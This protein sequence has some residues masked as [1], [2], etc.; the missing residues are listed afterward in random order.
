MITLKTA[1]AIFNREWLISVED[2]ERTHNVNMH[3]F[4]CFAI[5]EE[6]AIGKMYKHRPEFRHREIL[7]IT[8]V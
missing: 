6:E 7:S 2:K 3:T 8:Q 5:S 1:R 4:D